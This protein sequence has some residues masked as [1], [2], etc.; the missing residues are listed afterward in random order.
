ML[1]MLDLSAA[2]DSIDHNILFDRLSHSFGI[3]QSALNWIKSYLSNRNQK[4]KI[5]DLYSNELPINFGVP[6][7]SVLG[8]LLFTMYIYPMTEIIS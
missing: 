1:T 6:Q 8:P 2:F 3:N 4:I 7:G 5:N